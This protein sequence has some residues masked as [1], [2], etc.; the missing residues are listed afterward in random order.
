MK[1]EIIKLS[2]ALRDAGFKSEANAVSKIIKVSEDEKRIRAVVS[3]ARYISMGR[4]P[5]DQTKEV[6]NLKE[7][8]SMKNYSQAM[9]NDIIKDCK[10]LV[11]VFN[12][13]Y[14]DG[15]R[16]L[17]EISNTNAYIDVKDIINII[18]VGDMQE[19]IFNTDYDFSKDTRFS[20]TKYTSES[21]TGYKKGKDGYGEYFCDCKR[22]KIYIVRASDGKIITVS[23][24]PGSANYEHYDTIKTGV[25]WTKISKD[26]FL[27]GLMPYQ[28]SNKQLME[29][30]EDIKKHEG[31]H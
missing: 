14:R 20:E 13:G 8:F 6:L 23:N 26:E 21:E 16:P 9:R 25:S 15:T 10:R 28:S 11:A 30:V 2:K 22:Q 7:E 17:S 4:D 5:S 29:A 31:W 18:A 27:N 1:T 19:D 3:F 24:E 12:M